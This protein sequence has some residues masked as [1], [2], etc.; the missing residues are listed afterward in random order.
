MAEE[1]QSIYSV[2]PARQGEEDALVTLGRNTGLFTAEEADALLRSS[3]RSVFEAGGEGT[4]QCAARV[5]GSGD[6]TPLGWTYLAADA[7][8]GPG[9]WELYWIGVDVNF[10]GKGVGS[11]LLRDA[12]DTARSAGARM[13]L[14]S[15][16]STDATAAARDFYARRGYAQV[17][18]IPEY[19]GPGDDKVIFWRSL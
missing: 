6:D 12:E 8:G 5:V 18:R 17:G 14:I 10:Q 19:Y 3:L 4:P 13:L 16:S 11:E 15:T 7:M 2:R 1:N 9:V